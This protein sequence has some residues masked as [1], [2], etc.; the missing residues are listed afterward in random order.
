MR[1]LSSPA[2]WGYVARAEVALILGFRAFCLRNKGRY[3]QYARARSLRPDEAQA[4]VESVL[5][6][7]MMRWPRIIT[8]DRP[9]HEAW[10]LLAY[11]VATIV[12]ESKRAHDWQGG[13]TVHRT[14][15]G[16]EA[17]VVVLRYRLSLD[18]VQTADL[19]GLDVPEVTVSLR[20]GISELLAPR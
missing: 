11:Q 15:S 5:Q 17:D 19:M 18:P 2:H 20:K 14:L 6:A 16:Q 3:M 13:D 12:R 4:V 7:L 1:V 10:E 9:A 8:S